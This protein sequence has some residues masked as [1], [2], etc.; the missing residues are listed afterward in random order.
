MYHKTTDTCLVQTVTETGSVLYKK[1][2]GYPVVFE[3]NVKSICEISVQSTYVDSSCSRGVVNATF[4][5]VYML[6]SYKW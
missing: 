5:S 3:E 6:A 4:N 1:G 2:A